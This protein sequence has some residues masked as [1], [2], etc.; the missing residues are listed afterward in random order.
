MIGFPTVISHCNSALKFG[1]DILTIML[2]KGK[3]PK[4]LSRRE[5][6]KLV[7]E[8]LAKGA[9]VGYE[10]CQI[11]TIHARFDHSERELD[12]NDVLHGLK[13]NWESSKPDHFEEFF[14]QWH[15]IIETEDIEGEPLAVVVAVDSLNRS[16][17]VV[18]RWSIEKQ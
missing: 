17:E 18:T 2:S 9:Y 8:A 11:E 7:D 6:K 3:R 16:F 13:R 15:Y 12:V 14:W 4:P 10:E 5:L 1:L